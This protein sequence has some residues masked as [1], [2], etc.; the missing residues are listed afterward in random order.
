[1]LV[2]FIIKVFSL[3]SPFDYYSVISTYSS[4]SLSKL[5]LKL[6]LFSYVVTVKCIFGYL[7]AK[8]QFSNIYS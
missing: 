3:L 4:N 2:G 5:Y 7:L 8:V 1:M 6:T